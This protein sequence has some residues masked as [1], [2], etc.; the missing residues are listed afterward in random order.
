M[1]RSFWH[2]FQVT[3]AAIFAAWPLELFLIFMAARNPWLAWLLVSIIVG[4]AV[5]VVWLRIRPVAEGA[6]LVGAVAPAD[7]DGVYPCPECG[8]HWPSDRTPAAGWRC[9][10]CWQRTPMENRR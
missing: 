9:P 10:A 2:D 8:V 7:P 6:P 3:P 5:A 4:G 1:R